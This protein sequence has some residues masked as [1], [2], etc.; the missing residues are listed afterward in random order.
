[1]KLLFLTSRFPFPLEKGDKL[2]AFYFI[3]H[4]SRY[5]DVYLFAISDKQ[6]DIESINELRPYCKAIH[7]EVI[8]RL[9]SILQ[10]MRAVAGKLPMQVAWFTNRRAVSKLKS[11]AKE[12]HPDQVFCHLIRMGEYA[13][14]LPK[15]ESI[16]DYMD[17]FSKGLERQSA[18]SIW[19]EKYFILME[20]KRVLQYEANVYPNFKHHL[21]ISAQDRNFINHVDRQ[22]ITVVGNGV[23]FGYFIPT[24]SN[25]K[26]DLLFVG[27]MAYPP[28]I[29]AAI[30][31][32]KKILPLVHQTNPGVTFMIAGAEP[33]KKVSAL[34]TDKITVSGWVDDVRTV[35]ATSRIMIAPMLISIGLQNKILQAMAMKIPCVISTLA[36]NALGAPDDCV[37]VAD[38]EQDYA[39][40]ILYLLNE[41]AKANMMAMRAYEFVKA[42][43]DWD[44]SADIISNLI[45]K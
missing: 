3:K 12:H 10:M 6:P 45:R 32:A 18:F 29:E 43:Y 27:N 22:S 33:V 42:N 17:A 4:L 36:N 26:Y 16:I 44:R 23:E 7:V 37:C 9:Q 19:W 35:F 20:Y 13:A 30:Y 8:S 40:H 24:N 1:M 15:I 25:K 14:A 39:D 2:R 38:N 21:I 5:H 28:N 41:P 31:A 11:F 34:V